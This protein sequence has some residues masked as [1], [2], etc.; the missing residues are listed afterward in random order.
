[1]KY[2]TKANRKVFQVMSQNLGTIIVPTLHPLAM[3]LQWMELCAPPSPRN[4]YS[5]TSRAS[6]IKAL[7]SLE[8][9]HSGWWSCLAGETGQGPAA[10]S[11]GE[12]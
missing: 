2:V 1:M 4:R 12:K 10:P 6:L 8:S 5:I 3:L 7:A 9:S 11:S